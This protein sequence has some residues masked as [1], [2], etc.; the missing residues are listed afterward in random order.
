MPRVRTPDEAQR[1]VVPTHLHGPD[2]AGLRTPNHRTPALSSSLPQP[3]PMTTEEVTMRPY[4][5]SNRRAT[6]YELLE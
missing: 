3:L 2:P 5:P 4:L 1:S 6:T